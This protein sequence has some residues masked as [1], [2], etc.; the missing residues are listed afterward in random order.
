[1]VVPDEKVRVRSS[2]AAAIAMTGLMLLVLAQPMVASLGPF[3]TDVARSTYY[4]PQAEKRASTPPA[5]VCSAFHTIEPSPA[6]K[7]MSAHVVRGA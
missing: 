5:P 2:C 7:S 3:S 4:T 6:G 1:M